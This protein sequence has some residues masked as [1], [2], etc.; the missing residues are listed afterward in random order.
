MAGGTPSSG[1]AIVGSGVAGLHLALLLQ[2]QAIPV[3]LYSDQ[4]AAQL[5]SGR[6]LNT[7]AHH[8]TTVKREEALG[9]DHWDLAEYG[10]FCHHHYIGGP[11]PLSFPGAFGAPSRA[12]DYRVYLPRLLADFQERGGDFRA[13]HLVIPEE[14][15]RL[16]EQYDLV[17]VATGKGGTSAMFPVIPG[18]SPYSRPMRRLSAGLYHGIAP[19]EPKGVTMSIAPPHGELLEIPTFSANGH[20]TVLLFE[21]VPGGDTEI[22][23]DAKY[24]EDPAAFE[25]LVLEKVRTHHP[26]VFARIDTARFRLT[27]PN[28]LLQGAVTPVL[29]EDYAIL[30]NGRVVMAL[31]D[32]HSVVD[33]VVGQG[34]NS[35]SYSAWELGQVITEDQNFDERF[36]QKVAARRANRVRAISDWTNLM[37]GLPPAPHLLQLLGAMS[38]NPAVADE[39]TNN[40]NQPERQ[41]DILATP[42]RTAAFLARHGM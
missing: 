39:F 23:A 14:I 7:V 28:D 8:N 24:D 9:V 33:P 36:A 17:V 32:A 16:S 27:G 12:I 5:A 25:Q 35:A 15:V 4:T 34:A 1:I 30:P 29:R 31:G 13:G 26:E 42:E 6:M 20:V 19:S 40:F 22:L 10:Y 18:K 37:I 38:Q 11:Q 41:W 3:T 2:Q 21:N